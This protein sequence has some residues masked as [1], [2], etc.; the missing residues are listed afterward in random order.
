MNT[1]EITATTN[2]GSTVKF[3]WLADDSGAALEGFLKKFD[4]FIRLIHSIEI[5]EYSLINIGDK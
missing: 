4:K 5:F 3:K 2:A 1:Y